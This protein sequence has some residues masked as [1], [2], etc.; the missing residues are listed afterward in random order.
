M[1]KLESIQLTPALQILSQ[2][3]LTSFRAACCWG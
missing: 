1:V 2:N 3:Y